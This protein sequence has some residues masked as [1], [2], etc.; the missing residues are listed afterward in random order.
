MYLR[1]PSGTLNTHLF[2]P[3]AATNITLTTSWQRFS[4]TTTLPNG[5]TDLYLQ[6]AGAGSLTC[7]QPIQIWG[8]QMVIGSSPGVYDPTSSSTTS[9][10]TGQPGTLVQNGLNDVYGY[11][12]FGNMTRYNGWTPSYDANN[13]VVGWPY[14]AA[15][16]MLSNGYAQIQWDAESRISAVTGA[17]YLSGLEDL[18]G[19]GG[20]SFNGSLKGRPSTT[21]TSQLPDG[22]YFIRTT[23]SEYT[24]SLP[25]PNLSAFATVFFFGGQGGANNG[26]R[27]AGLNP[28]IGANPAN[29]NY[30]VVYPYS[31]RAGGPATG[32][33]AHNQIPYQSLSREI[34]LYRGEWF[35]RIRWS[36][37]KHEKA[38]RSHAHYRSF[39]VSGRQ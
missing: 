21:G 15:G 30:N 11:D 16:N 17:S 31:A 8:A 33:T 22:S 36:G 38:Q 10:V 14:D 29:L 19:F 23:Y 35:F 6:I 32:T 7:G 5:L 13:H 4:I 26:L 37:S 3:N 28:C 34:Y 9:P 18:F 39:A 1:V 27:P 25:N 24:Y 12:S 20:S 2:L